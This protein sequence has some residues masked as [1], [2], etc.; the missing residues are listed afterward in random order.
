MNE[1]YAGKG[2]VMH[3]E[4]QTNHFPRDRRE[5]SALIKEELHHRNIS[6]SSLANWKKRRR[7]RDGEWRGAAERRFHSEEESGGSDPTRAAGGNKA[8]LNRP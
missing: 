7:K 1:T 4:L 3:M 2:S 5:D 8:P 6:K